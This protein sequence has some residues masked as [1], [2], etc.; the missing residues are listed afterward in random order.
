RGGA[1][2]VCDGSNAPSP[3]GSTPTAVTRGGGSGEE[4][5]RAFGRRADGQ[6]LVAGTYYGDDAIFAGNPLPYGAGPNEGVDVFVAAY[7][8]S[9]TPTWAIGLTGDDLQHPA[10][11]TVD[12]SNHAFVAGYFMGTIDTSPALVGDTSLAADALDGFVVKLDPGGAVAWQRRFGGPA[13]EVALGVATDSNGDVLVVGVGKLDSNIFPAAPPTVTT[14]FGCGDHQV[15][16]DEGF[17]FTVKLSGSDGSCLWDRFDAVETGFANYWNWTNG[18]AVAVTPDDHV[19]VVGGASGSTNNFG[20]GPLDAFGGSDIF[21]LETDADGH[22]LWA[23]SYGDTESQAAD[24][25]AVDPC[26]DLVLSGWFHGSVTI[27]TKG[28]TDPANDPNDPKAFVAKLSR[29]GTPA[30]AASAMWVRAFVDVGQVTIESLAVG[31]DADVLLG[32]TLLSRLGSVGVDFGDG[33]VA[34]PPGPDGTNYRED[35]FLA[36]YR[37]DGSARWSRRFGTVAAEAI[38]GA[39]F[40]DPGTSY[41]AGWFE[42]PYDFGTGT[43]RTPNGRDAF[44]LR[45]AP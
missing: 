42:A 11:L 14:Q 36:R 34:P 15:T 30:T 41:A 25:V 32:G 16:L 23:S 20:Q 40:G 2:P 1:A 45:V 26:G 44:L 19:L 6:L 35:G 24:R 9:G 18:A 29:V 22:Y 8:P 13:N 43:T 31:A 21:V 3:D 28:A 37:G 33:A 5:A 39:V 7:G 10:A 4:T 38:R 27:G 12:G 17:V